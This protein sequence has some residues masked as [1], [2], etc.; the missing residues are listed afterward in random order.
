MKKNNNPLIENDHDDDNN[1]TPMTPKEVEI[2]NIQ[3]DALIKNEEISAY[4]NI[5]N[6]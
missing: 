1:N 5:K 3:E 4:K 6:R 2:P